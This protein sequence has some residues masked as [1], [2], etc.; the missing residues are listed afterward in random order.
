MS[1]PVQAKR[2]QQSCQVRSRDE[3]IRTGNIHQYTSGD[4]LPPQERGRER[5]TERCR[6]RKNQTTAASEKHEVADHGSGGTT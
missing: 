3:Y 5:S 4:R 2:N 6:D 1:K